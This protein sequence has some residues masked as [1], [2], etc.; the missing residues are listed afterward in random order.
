VQDRDDAFD[1][2]V[3]L[4]DDAARDYFTVI[5]QRNLT[6]HKDKTVGD[7]CLAKGQVLP[8]CTRSCAANAFDRQRTSS[9]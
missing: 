4:G 3:S 5:A 8:A 7:R 9:G 2:V 1:A 6:G